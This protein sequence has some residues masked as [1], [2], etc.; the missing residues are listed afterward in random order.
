MKT[1]II[2]HCKNS[3]KSEPKNVERGKID[4]LNTYITAH[5]YGFVQTLQ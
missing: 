5:F 3:S 4:T 1:K 2:A